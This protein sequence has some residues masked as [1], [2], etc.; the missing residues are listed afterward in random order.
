[1]FQSFSK[2]AAV[3]LVFTACAALIFSKSPPKPPES[4]VD[5]LQRSW[6]SLSLGLERALQINTP[7]KD[8]TF[9]HTHNSYNSSKYTTAFSYLDP[10]QNE[11]IY[12]QLRMGV[13]AIELDVHW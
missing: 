11:T 5:R 10:N 6:E 7:L 1:M 8:A 12:D 9:L 13:R 3:G 4:A 2:R